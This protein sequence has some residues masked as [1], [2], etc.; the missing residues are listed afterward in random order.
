MPFAT[1]SFASASCFLGLQDI[2]IGFGL[3]GVKSYKQIWSLERILSGSRLTFIE[4][5]ELPFGIIGKL[6]G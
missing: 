5:I 2:Q 1:G 4:E 3:P 6:V